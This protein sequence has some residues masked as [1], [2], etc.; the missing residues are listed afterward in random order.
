MVIW[1]AAVRP[2]AAPRRWC[3]V[4]QSRP[5]GIRPAAMALRNSPIIRVWT[6]GPG[7]RGPPSRQAG[8]SSFLCLLIR[9]HRG[10]MLARPQPVG[11]KHRACRRRGGDNDIRRPDRRGRH[12]GLSHRSRAPAKAPPPPLRFAGIPRP[13][14]MRPDRTN[15]AQRLELQPRLACPPRGCRHATRRRARRCRAA[16]APGGSGADI[17]E[18]AIVEQQRLEHSG[19][20][21]EQHHQS[22]CARQADLGVVEEARRDLDRETVDP[23]HDRPS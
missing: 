17:G 1:S 2:G 15:Q 20:C 12:P 11:L 9:A 8:S 6:G 21:R 10:D 3:R 16:T 19:P 18:I 13:D 22:G 23:G 4:R 7:H 5:A 14:R